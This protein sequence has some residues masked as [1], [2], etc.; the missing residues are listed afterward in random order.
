MR[1]SLLICT[2][3]V[4][5]HFLD[6]L[7]ASLEEQ[8]VSYKNNVEILI[9]KDNGRR[10]IG[11]K[12]NVLMHKAC[13]DYVAFIDDDDLVAN[14]YIKLIMKGLEFNEDV[15]GIE[16]VMKTNNKNPKR[17]THS[18][19]YSRWFEKKG[20]YYRPPNHLNPVKREIALKCDFPNVNNYEDR[21]YSKKLR[22]YLKTEHYISKPIY[23]YLYRTNK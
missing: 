17:F 21:E 7:M 2:L 18:I 5:K 14:S 22:R 13:G 9:E 10:T 15:C 1:L 23:Y 12:R 6:R 3:G 16:G 19:R 4:R 11:Y 8:I 20:V